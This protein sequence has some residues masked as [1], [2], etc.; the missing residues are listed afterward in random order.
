M[1]HHPSW[2]AP[3]PL[4]AQLIDQ[5]AS[6]AGSGC[7]T[8]GAVKATYGTGV[9]VLAH[10]GTNVPAATGGLLPTVA[11]SDG[12]TVTYA[13]DGGVFTAGALLEWL[14]TGLGL[15]A[16]PAGLC[17]LAA[18][19]NN[20]AGVRVLPALAGL[21]APWWQPSARGVVA[22]LHDGVRAGHLA[23]AAL[24]AITE[25]V[26]DILDELDQEGRPPP[27]LRVDGGLSRDDLLLQL[28]ADAAGRPVQ[29]TVADATARGAAL[30]AAV[31]AGVIADVT[32]AAA[33]VTVDPPIQP[34]IDVTSRE[35]HR[36]T[37]RAWVATAGVL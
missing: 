36:A 13:K 34:R 1:L 35:L 6:L 14:S 19:V 17:A 33:A 31:G 27:A 21:G 22:G 32:S 29:R 3:L 26:A 30:L 18:D 15:A 8:P 12:T 16:D 24:E 7:V 4:R 11:W 23:R 37:W 9:F 28:Q 5:Q 20:S 2:Q 10:A 25:R